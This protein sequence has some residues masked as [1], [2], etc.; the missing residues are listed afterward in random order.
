[1]LNKENIEFLKNCEDLLKKATLL[2]N[3]T[4]EGMIDKGGYPYIN[5]LQFVSNKGTD[6]DRK[7]VGMLHDVLEHTVVSKTI[8]L[9]LGFP[10]YIVEAVDIL[11]NKN[12]D[13]DTYIDRIVSSEND[14]A[15]EVKLSDL[16]HNMDI[17]RMPN[18]KNED[19]LRIQKYK[20]A[21]DK[22]IK[23]RG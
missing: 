13:Y 19:Y 17:S 4:F 7:I 6:E 11:T 9:E 22:L 12:E 16:E 2:V 1:M 15:I 21:Y 10:E 14:I 18:P 23:K 3:I 5:H 20:K 8:L